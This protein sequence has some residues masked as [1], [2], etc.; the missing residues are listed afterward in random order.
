MVSSDIRKGVHLSGVAPVISVEI[1]NLL[2]AFKKM[3]TD[4]TNEE[5]ALELID[6]IVANAKLTQEERDAQNDEAEKQLQ[7]EEPEVF[8]TLERIKKGLLGGENE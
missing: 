1:E 5:F 6:D 2:I 4:N 3:V 8:E 7:E